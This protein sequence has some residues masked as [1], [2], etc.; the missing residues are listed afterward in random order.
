MESVHNVS[1]LFFFLLLLIAF[2][3][4]LM[5]FESFGKSKKSKMTDLGWLPCL[6]IISNFQVE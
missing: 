6:K 1:V 4:I 5:V 2:W 3:P